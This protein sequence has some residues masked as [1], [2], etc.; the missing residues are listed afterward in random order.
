MTAGSENEVKE[1]HYVCYTCEQALSDRELEWE[2]A[3]LQYRLTNL[4]RMQ[5]Q[6]KAPVTP[7]S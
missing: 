6:R 1:L 4:K 2:I 7:P 3:R 5:A